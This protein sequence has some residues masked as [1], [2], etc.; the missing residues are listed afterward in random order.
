M[1]K[2][3]YR[4]CLV[5]L[6]ALGAISP[7]AK[8]EE[9]QSTPISF[10]REVAPILVGKC[11]ACHGPKTA[12]SNYRLDTF[13]LLMQPGDFASPPITAADLE[14]S[15]VHRLITSEDSEERMP[16]NGD[17]LADSEIQTIN[18][19]ITQGAKFDGQ[20]PASPLRDQIPKD[21]P[22]PAAP[23]TYSKALPVTAL[24]F[25]TDGNQLLV[26]G[27]HEIMI[28]DSA[29]G[30]LVARV[31]NIAQRTL[32]FAFSPD[33]S[34]LAIAGGAPGVS[35]EVRL[36][37]WQNGPKGDAPPI[38]L[39]TQDDVFFDVAFSFDGKLLAAGG[40]DGSVRVFEVATGTERLKIDNHADWVL[41]VCFS[42]DGKRIAT[43][44]RDKTAKV[45]DV[46]TGKLLTTH[47]EHNAP[48]RAVAFSPDGKQVLSAAGR[49]I[50]VWNV[51]DSALIA[52]IPGFE[53]DIHEL[54]LDSESIV[55]VSADRTA[56]HFKLAD[57]TL[58]RSLADH[59]AAV[60]SVAWHGPSHR[61]ATGCFDGTVTV[62]NL[63]DGT[64][65]KQYLA[66]PATPAK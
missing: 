27:Y 13:Q 37:P 64:K 23:L 65:V 54:L 1:P 59:P 45:F 49:Q 25:T 50:R 40:A 16:N 42:P 5:I 4:K 9:S 21:I 6:A 44:S 12:E 15:E 30:T 63:D 7:W 29:I 28:W 61:I 41:D 56:K 32:G 57:R 11:Q 17:R 14:N 48:V 18:A 52:E 26:G 46:E 62:W 31:G 58:V 39:A 20:D 47:S 60:L 10:V 66:M 43:A 36:I 53:N 3:T 55:A 51:E 33:N 19:W 8:C 24:A 35:G 34:W 38:V 2:K 22:H